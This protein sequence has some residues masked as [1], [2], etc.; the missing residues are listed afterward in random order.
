MCLA[1]NGFIME[2]HGSIPVSNPGTF[3]VF[4]PL[5]TGD[6]SSDHKVGSELKMFYVGDNRGYIAE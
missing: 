6:S 3:T 4:L 1:K 5:H 2:K